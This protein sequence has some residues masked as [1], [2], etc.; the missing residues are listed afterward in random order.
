MLS[1]RSSSPIMER[2][3][4]SGGDMIGVGRDAHAS[5]SSRPIISFPLTEVTFNLHLYKCVR[6]SYMYIPVPSIIS[7]TGIAV[8]RLGP[9]ARMQKYYYLPEF[10]I[11]ILMHFR[12]GLALFKF[13]HI[14]HKGIRRPTGSCRQQVQQPDQWRHL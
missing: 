9:A 14:S 3:G 11:G 8:Q 5:S 6:L 13:K 2:P 7:D 10:S 12:S 1:G 4:A